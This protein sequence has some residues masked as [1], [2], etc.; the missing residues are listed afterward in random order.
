MVSLG[1][2]K[3]AT[4]RLMVVNDHAEQAENLANKLRNNGIAVR[5]LRPNSLEECVTLLS[6]AHLAD[7]LDVVVIQKDNISVPIPQLIA[8]LQ[9]KLVPPSDDQ[10]KSLSN[11]HPFLNGHLDVSVI[12]TVAEYDPSAVKQLLDSGVCAVAATT[13]PEVLSK[14]VSKEWGHVV[15][16]RT[17]KQWQRQLQEANRRCDALIDSSRD[18]IAYIHEGMHIRANEAYLQAFGFETFEDVEGI[19]VLDL[20]TS[21]YLPQFKQLLKQLSKGEDVPPDI[22]VDA[23]TFEGNSFPAKIEF[24]TATYEGEKCLQVVVRRTE[25]ENMSSAQMQEILSKDP[26]TGLLSRAAF[27]NEVEKAFGAQKPSALQSAGH[28][29]LLIE[30]D[31]YQRLVQNVGLKSVDLLLQ[32]LGQRLKKIVDS[33]SLVKLAPSHFT[34]HVS[35]LSDHQF[36]VFFSSPSHKVSSELA[37][38]IRQGFSE[39]LL[40]TAGHSVTLTMSIGGVHS[41]EAHPDSNAVLSKAL[42]LLHEN[43]EQGGNRATVF[44]PSAVDLAAAEEMA[45]NVE[46]IRSALDNGSFSV[47][48]QPLIALHGA[49]IDLYEMSTGVPLGNGQY[50]EGFRRMATE[51]GLIWEVNRWNVEKAIASIA[52]HRHRDRTT[53]LVKISEASIQDDSLIQHIQELLAVHKIEGKQ[54]ILE[55]PETKISTH[56]KSAQTFRLKLSNVGVRVGLEHFGANVDSMQLLNHFNADVLK[57]STSITN[58]VGVS[59]EQQDKMRAMSN[60]LH[61]QGKQVLVEQ[62]QDALTMSVLFSAGIDYAQG[63]FL[64]PPQSK[65]DYD[66]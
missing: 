29:L 24:T 61:A 3:S 23:K 65:M 58:G 41:S 64:A 44:D 33:S 60:T 17:M 39:K 50:L 25:N 52:S 66:F 22:S 27:I 32:S 20:V 55:L 51:Q 6:G 4:L 9:S 43:Q 1:L 37:E 48:F 40:D 14:M 45:K 34:L 36:A 12:A 49:P 7:V 53:M 30:P 18:P 35:R 38:T 15:A 62:V 8:L 16:R 19:S 59:Q 2:E 10:E 5:M 47:R 56:L 42:F 21:Q 26:V 63:D 31:H 13:E 57:L 11:S 28:S 46:L 54:L